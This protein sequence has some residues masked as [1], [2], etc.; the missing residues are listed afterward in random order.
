LKHDSVEISDVVE[1]GIQ[2]CS[3][4]SQA[5]Q[6]NII[7]RDIKPE[8]IMVE[9]SGSAKVMDF[10]I[11]KFI[12]TATITREGEILGTVAY[13]SPQQ[14]VGDAIDF[15][16][17]IFSLGSVLYQLLTG[18]L[19]F[20][21]EQPIVI[22]YSLLNEEP[23]RIR[24]LREDVPM[25]LEQIVFKALRKTPQDRYQNI[26]EM[27]KD[28]ES[29]KDYLEGKTEKELLELVATEEVF[30]ESK[31]ELSSDL[32]GRQKEFEFLKESMGKMLLREGSAV[33]IAG[34]AGIGKTRIV[35]ELAN[36]AREKNVR[37]LLGRCIL[38]E[39]S[40]PYQ[41]FIEIIRKYLALKDIKKETQLETFV[42]EKLP[43]LSG[44]M[45]ILKVFLNVTD[46]DESV[47]IRKEQLWDAITKLIEN[48]SKERPV[49]L[50]LDDIHWADESSL[51]L[52]YYLARNSRNSRVLILCTFR[53]EDVLDTEKEHPFISVQREMRREGL[54]QEI[55]LQR[56][57]QDDI[58]Q[59]VTSVFPGFDF[60]HNL[61]RMLHQ[62]TEGNPFF[63]LEILKLLKGEGVVEKEN[64]G[65]ILKKDM[66]KFSIPNKVY[67]VVI[68]RVSK[69]EQQ[70]K[71][72]LEVAAVDGEVF[73]S[74][75]VSNC[76]NY[77]RIALLKTLQ[78]LEKNH[79]LIKARERK[80]RF[81]HSKIREILY[82]NIIPE[83][84]IEYHRLMGEYYQK[85][86]R[87]QEEYV[88]II[89]HHLYEGDQ[90]EDALPY[91]ISAGDAAT[92]LFANQNALDYYQKALEVLEKE[93]EE[94]ES[95]LLILYHK[96]AEVFAKLSK[97][98]EGKELAEGSI[99]L[100]RK[101]KDKKLEGGFL[102][103]LG[104]F[105]LRLAEHEDAL[106]HFSDAIEI[107]Q[108][109]ENKK[110]E[111]MALAH[112]GNVYLEKGDYDK[113]LDY[114]H[115]ALE[116]NSKVKDLR[117]EATW[118]GNIAIIYDV[119]GIY[120][121]ALEYYQK[122]LEIAKKVGDKAGMGRH[123]QNKAIIFINRG[124][125]DAAL[126]QFEQVL[127]IAQEIGDRRVEG[128]VLGNIG[129]V[130]CD[131]KEY[132]L[133]L[134]YYQRALEIAHKLGD[135]RFEGVWLGY[136]GISHFH[137][138]E[139]E[140][141]TG[142]LEKSLGIARETGHKGREAVD[143]IYYGSTKAH[144]GDV[145]EGINFINQGIEIAQKID[146]K[147]YLISGYLQL[148]KAYHILRDFEKSK[149]ILKK[150][151][152]LAQET[153]NINLCEK[154]REELKGLQNNS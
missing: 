25:E 100:A 144:Q 138:K 32:V 51:Q 40:L 33:F 151:E 65:W 38:G 64:G 21:G 4:L 150:A 113:A 17:D 134:R 154:V 14:A 43:L 91:L 118:L 24:E 81:D 54:Y 27:Q 82:Q 72:I 123:M 142:C 3:A 59:M 115:Q 62:E 106:V 57:D 99:V 9:E 148:G 30:L 149:E 85:N 16:S 37:Y 10:G 19:P 90:K 13:M 124:E 77:N 46:V 103:F 83:L 15:R 18:K 23:M 12:D 79:H 143:L 153:K 109:T 36:C 53:P 7:H 28:L 35:Q 112:S 117:N 108:E 76:L 135:I 92:K 71:E 60:N 44:R 130:Y 48:I 126:S 6:K 86:Y 110:L 97:F 127:K 125:F 141:A 1:I 140:Q 41:P 120:D 26:S 133:S 131:K 137:K 146:E 74:D 39:G 84:R 49:L 78:H 52:L 50:H 67:D 75:S 129:S 55:K 45:T 73:Q 66:E 102:R 101:L 31:E 8:N 95:Q 42:T 87:S 34:E 111:S 147:E 89:A 68:R 152:K 105:N 70:E 69:L 22:V 122:A 80:Y 58:K 104:D 20:T 96:E 29:F 93:P 132:D 98:K 107:A 11:A 121:S 47:L 119:R 61:M 139:Y 145:E 128:I 136:I 116:L 5:H 114:Y 2:V 88:A 63:V 94:N 56:L